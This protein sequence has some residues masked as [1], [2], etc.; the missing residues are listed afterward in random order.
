MHFSWFKKKPQLPPYEDRVW[1]T[2]A[3]RYNA[4]AN[5]LGNAA[6]NN[7]RALIIAHFPD[8]LKELHLE[9]K[10]RKQPIF[11]LLNVL[12]LGKKTLNE[13]QLYATTA[14]KLK[15]M[16]LINAANTNTDDL[17]VVILEHYPL[18]DADEQL[19]CFLQTI[20]PKP[21]VF[22]LSLEDP[23]LQRLN[24]NKISDVLLKMGA[25]E[26]EYIMHP[27]ITQ[28]LVNAQ[29]KIAKQVYF[30]IQTHSAQDWIQKNY[31]PKD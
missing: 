17:E 29:H 15:Q 2:S 3:N 22:Q 11:E 30:E 8:T 9:M 20:T 1:L 7:I 6:N 19:L 31:P 25:T 4:L 28:A 26:Q 18:P 21:P 13:P 5:W 24:G 14:Q 23:F 27:L 10:L 16:G 12:Q